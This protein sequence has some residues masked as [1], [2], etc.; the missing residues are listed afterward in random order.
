M[1]QDRKPFSHM[2]KLEL[3]KINDEALYQLAFKI[4]SL[5]ENA[6]GFQA[7]TEIY[8][9]IINR[10]RHDNPRLFIKGLIEALDLIRYNPAK[11]LEEIFDVNERIS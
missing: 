11:S 3:R 1:I 4:I 10:I 9:F 2:R 6:N 7:D 8:N 5:Y